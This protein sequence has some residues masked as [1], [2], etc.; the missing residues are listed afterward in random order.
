MQNK[1]LL[2]KWLRGHS[3][4]TGYRPIPIEEFLVHQG[5]IYA[6]KDTRS[7]SNSVDPTNS[8]GKPRSQG[9]PLGCVEH[10]EHKPF[11]DC[12]L[13]AVVSLAHETALTGSGVLVFAGSRT[14]CESDARWISR[15]MPR[16]D[17]LPEGVASRRIDLLADL[18]SLSIDLDPVL[19]DT[20]LYGVAFHRKSSC[21]IQRHQ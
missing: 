2:A 12:V 16:I 19:E 1:D 4:E 9:V 18:R 5:K 11:E 13:N 17:E 10:S 14:L 15:V 7:S 6:S 8:A 20:V 3:F 21:S